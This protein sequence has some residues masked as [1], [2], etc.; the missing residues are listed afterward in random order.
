MNR[1]TPGPDPSLDPGSADPGLPAASAGAVQAG[2]CG[3][4]RPVPSGAPP[5]LLMTT[6]VRPVQGGNDEPSRLLPS[7]ASP[8]LLTSTAVGPVQP[9]LDLP[10]ARVSSG[11]PVLPAAPAAAG[12]DPAC[13]GSRRPRPAPGC[14]VP[15][16]DVADVIKELHLIAAYAYDKAA[17]D[18]RAVGRALKGL[19]AARTSAGRTSG[20]H[21]AAV[22]ES[23]AQAHQTISDDVRSCAGVLA[24]AVA[25][26]PPGDRGLTRGARAA[27]RDADV[28][29][30]VAAALAHAGGV[31]GVLSAWQPGLMSALLGPPG[32]APAAR[33]DGG[34]PPPFRRGIQRFVPVK[35]RPLTPP[36]VREEA[37]RR[38]GRG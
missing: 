33:P 7:G 27:L 38:P 14:D 12:D 37:A 35:E 25:G 8:G 34:G 21:R 26:T 17:A 15:S 11:P 29:V 24:G 9:G 19:R 28:A 16:P 36:A 3:P 18:R 23:R 1:S 31:L 32:E 6:A 4:F 10:V 5:L 30:R 20:L 2:R 22:L 13:P